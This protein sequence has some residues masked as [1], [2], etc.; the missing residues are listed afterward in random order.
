[1]NSI[2]LLLPPNF[3]PHEQPRLSKDIGSTWNGSSASLETA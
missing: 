3:N 1:M 2:A